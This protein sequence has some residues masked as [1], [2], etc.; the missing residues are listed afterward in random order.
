MT[1]HG[2]NFDSLSDD[3]LAEI[4]KRVEHDEESPRLLFGPL[5]PFGRASP[6]V[7]CRLFV[8]IGGKLRCYPEAG[9]LFVDEYADK[10][11]LSIRALEACGLGTFQ[12]VDIAAKEEGEGRDP[13]YCRQPDG[14]LG[15][16]IAKFCQRGVQVTVADIPQ[17][18][19]EWAWGLMLEVL[20]AVAERADEII[21]N[22]SRE[23]E[24]GGALSALR[25]R[26]FDR[27]VELLS[28]LPELKIL[29]CTGPYIQSLN[30]AWR[31]L[32]K[33]L[34]Q[35]DIIA[36]TEE[37]DETADEGSVWSACMD[38]LQLHCRKLMSIHMYSPIMD[39]AEV[40]EERYVS[41]LTSYGDQLL[42]A[43]LDLSFLS[44]SSCERIAE[45]CG[46]LQAEV[47]CNVQNFGRLAALNKT[48]YSVYFSLE[49]IE[50]WSPLSEVMERIQS[51]TEL[52]VDPG[53]YFSANASVPEEFIENMFTPTLGSLN[54][55]LIL[56]FMS[57]HC[58]SYITESTSNLV[59]IR[60]G[61]ATLETVDMSQLVQANR[62]LKRALIR[63]ETEVRH[64][65]RTAKKIASNLI[66]TFASAPEM[67]NIE[68]RFFYPLDR[69]IERNV[70][71][72]YRT[73]PKLNILFSSRSMPN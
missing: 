29:N 43:W 40:S 60:L 56:H 11:I 15:W 65:T 58:L 55:L 4:V 12:R 37:L 50:D 38:Q 1:N 52:T 62:F 64:D 27:F 57:P 26:R 54:T 31:Y 20:N 42:T 72:P 69:S 47:G 41:F 21:F 28:T 61:F 19:A 53:R 59:D 32:G 17:E 9:I 49:E 45:M 22:G 51:V 39:D 3:L 6:L 68:I 18:P 44:S 67:E 71:S 63:E 10:D 5:S 25:R 66:S 8:V 13:V 2:T 73:K 16:F 33:S 48:A 46:N 23:K 7:F 36:T 24:Y 35:V 34:V 70:L 30:R 14:N